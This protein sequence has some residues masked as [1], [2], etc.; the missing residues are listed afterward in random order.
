MSLKETNEGYTRGFGK[1]KG[2]L[3]FNLKKKN[4]GQFQYYVLRD[5]EV[6]LCRHIR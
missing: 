6:L 5:G 4:R 3:I 1:K 2:K